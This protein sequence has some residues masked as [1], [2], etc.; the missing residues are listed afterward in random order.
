MKN[1]HLLGLFLITAATLIIEVAQ[2]RVLSVIMHYHLVFIVVSMAMFGLAAGAIIVHLGRLGQNESE[3]NLSLSNWSLSFAISTV[4][5]MALEPRI[6]I[7]I[8]IWPTAV[9]PLFLMVLCITIPFVFSGVVVCLVLTKCKLAPGKAYCADM[10]G[11]ACGCL[12]VLVIMGVTTGPSAVLW[13]ASLS[14]VAALVFYGEF[15]KR[16]FVLSAF[17]LLCAFGST[18]DFLPFRLVR[19]KGRL[20]MYRTK[21]YEEWN[22]FSRITV[23]RHPGKEPLMWGPSPKFNK[24]RWEMS[25]KELLIDGD[26]TTFFYHHEG[27][28]DKLGFLKED[29]TSLAYWLPERESVAVIGSGGG[30]D[31]LTAKVFG[32]TSVLGVELNPIFRKLMYDHPTYSAYAGMKELRGVN[33]VV[34]EARSWFFRTNQ[35]FDIIQMSLIDTWAATQAGAFTLSE[36]GLYTVEGWQLFLSKLT[37]RGALTV[38]R[39]FTPGAVDE[40]GR[41]VSLAMATL[42]REG[43]QNPRQHIFLA[44]SDR[45]ATLVLRKSPFSKSEESALVKACTNLGYAIH[46]APSQSIENGTFETI[47]QSKTE[48][49][50]SNATSPLALDLSPATDDKPFFFVLVPFHHL[51]KALAQLEKTGMMKEGKPTLIWGNVKAALLLVI[52]LVITMVIVAAIVTLPYLQVRKTVDREYLFAATFYFFLIGFGFMV[53]E[54][55]LLQRVSVFLGHPVYALGIVLFTIICSAGLGSYLSERFTLV[56]GKRLYQWALLTFLFIIFF[57]LFGQEVLRAFVSSRLLVRAAIAGL[58]LV[59]AGL[60]LGFAFPTG[61]KVIQKIDDRPAPWLWGVNGGAGVLGSVIATVLSICC[62]ITTTL[63]VGGVSYLLTLLFSPTLLRRYESRCS[64]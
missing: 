58:I 26:A 22:S 49:E 38:S 20:H 13:G 54:I 50:L 12:G 3:L 34:D 43:S 18:A 57:A 37:E 6:F 8:E 2:T 33:V 27:Q 1:R 51:P 39:W 59:P 29:V 36:N 56:K 41:M 21:E 35:R 45:I 63:I 23:H 61:L 28:L 17:V 46:L 64:S 7:P 10:L 32:C 40:T 60:L 42:M 9:I 62:G 47:C 52:L 30:R 11:A 31:L 55:G 15:E 48:A 4:F 5:A 24:N 53:V 44:T 19:V 25:Q 16:R 14:A